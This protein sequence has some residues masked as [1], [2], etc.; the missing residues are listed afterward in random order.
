MLLLINITGVISFASRLFTEEA[1]EGE[2]E[3]ANPPEMQRSDLSAAVL[4]LKALGIDSVLRFDFPSPPPA[5][6]LLSA[7]ELCYALGAIDDSG[8]LTKPLGT[9]MAE[10]PLPPLFAKAL[11]ISGEL[12]GN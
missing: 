8:Q 1:F 5:S 3:E 7:L 11:V 6:N 2:L 12:E 10:L 4:Q 9:T